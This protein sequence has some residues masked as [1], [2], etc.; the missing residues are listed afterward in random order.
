MHGWKCSTV[1]CCVGNEEKSRTDWLLPKNINKWMV[2]R[3]FGAFKME[4]DRKQVS[5]GRDVR[6]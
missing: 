6:I 3:Q 4:A 5:M 2:T 1:A